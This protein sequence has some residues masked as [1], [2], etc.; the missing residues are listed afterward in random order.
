MGKQYITTIAINLSG[1]P[2]KSRLRN[3]VWLFYQP[4]KL[5]EEL[6]KE[7]ADWSASG[8]FRTRWQG[9]AYLLDH[10]VLWG[11]YCLVAV[12]H[13]SVHGFRWSIPDRGCKIYGIKV[14]PPAER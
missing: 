11:G 12:I 6:R 5:R 3:F 9:L 7:Y 2:L 1:I 14:F 8:V 10:Y 4:Y 13:S